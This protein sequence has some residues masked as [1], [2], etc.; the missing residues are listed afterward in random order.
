MWIAALLY[1]YKELSPDSF[2]LPF[3]PHA[4]IGTDKKISEILSVSNMSNK[5]HYAWRELVAKKR[6]G[7]HGAEL[8]A[9]QDFDDSND[10]DSE[11]GSIDDTDMADDDSDGKT[12][13][14]GATNT[15]TDL[16]AS[17]NEVT[18]ALTYL[19]ST[20]G[21]PTFSSIR[22]GD[23]IV[24]IV[25]SGHAAMLPLVPDKLACVLR[26]KAQMHY[27]STV[28]PGNTALAQHLERLDSWAGFCIERYFGS[29]NLNGY[30]TLRNFVRLSMIFRE[31]PPAVVSGLATLLSAKKN[32]QREAAMLLK[33][34]PPYA[35]LGHSMRIFNFVVPM[36]LGP[37]ENAFYGMYAAECA[38]RKLTATCTVDA[39]AATSAFFGP[40]PARCSAEDRKRL[41]AE[42]CKYSLNTGRKRIEMQRSQH[43]L[44]VLEALL[45]LLEAVA[46]AAETLPD[47]KI[48]CSLPRTL[49]ETLFVVPSAMFVSRTLAAL[50]A[51]GRNAHMAN[52]NRG[53]ATTVGKVRRA[54]ADPEGEYSLVAHPGLRYLAKSFAEKARVQAAKSGSGR[55]D[56]SLGNIMKKHK[57]SLVKF[58]ANHSVDG[59]KKFVD[60]WPFDSN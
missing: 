52:E 22:D 11:Q 34:I 7:E 16:D 39:D 28:F 45:S 10:N 37:P 41:V 53:F 25:G 49:V 20:G 19:V 33:W 55:V 14:T 2:V 56:T 3:D 1:K 48:T 24:H 26:S 58:Y 54:L 35:W 8:P 5:R 21:L 46:E 29:K 36:I 27:V 32:S 60:M 15:Q 57:A 38:I 13:T 43:H 44:T 17:F 9:Y 40:L 30:N 42:L 51:L 50:A 23:D 47:I 12:I 31:V 6:R 59:I 18:P 4:I